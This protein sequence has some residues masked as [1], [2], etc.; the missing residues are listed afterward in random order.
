MST[1]PTE[2]L[3]SLDRD[4]KRVLKSLTSYNPQ[5]RSFTVVDI[6]MEAVGLYM[7]SRHQLRTKEI[8]EEFPEHYLSHQTTKDYAE[9][10]FRDEVTQVT[11]PTLLEYQ[12]NIIKLI[13]QRNV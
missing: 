5:D 8:N 13:Q 3:I 9:V 12:D 6:V 2:F 1:C 7:E 11:I 10:I 4:S